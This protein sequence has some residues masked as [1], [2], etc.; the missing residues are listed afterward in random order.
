MVVEIVQFYFDNHYHQKIR[1]NFVYCNCLS[2]YYRSRLNILSYFC[3]QQVQVFLEVLLYLVPSV[4]D[5][6]VY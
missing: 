5:H 4:N 6:I 2:R 1:R 3:I